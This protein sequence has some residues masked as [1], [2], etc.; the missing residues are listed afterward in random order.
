MNANPIENGNTSLQRAEEI[1]QDM[2]TS[3]KTLMIEDSTA[4]N[5]STSETENS[6]VEGSKIPNDN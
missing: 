4:M 3:L 1:L 5:I 2:E 6:S